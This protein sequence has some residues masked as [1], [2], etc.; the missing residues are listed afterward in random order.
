MP[1]VGVTQMKVGVVCGSHTNDYVTHGYTLVS[2]LGFIYMWESH[3]SISY[4]RVIQIIVICGC[5]T[6]KKKNL[7]RAK[8]LSE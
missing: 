2:W 5:H 1:Y 8:G 6:P 7:L 4:V 3:T